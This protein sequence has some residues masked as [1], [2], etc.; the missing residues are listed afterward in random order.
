[1]SKEYIKREKE[2]VEA[3]KAIMDEDGLFVR[4]LSEFW[5]GS[6]FAETSAFGLYGLWLDG[7]GSSTIN[8]KRIADY[9]NKRLFEGS[10]ELKNFCKAHDLYLE[11]YD[12]E[13]IMLL[14]KDL[15]KK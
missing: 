10:N 4:P 8:G 2:V 5:R 3:M 11:W 14:F 1:M 7:S 15:I 6:T 12:P 13:T 9:Y